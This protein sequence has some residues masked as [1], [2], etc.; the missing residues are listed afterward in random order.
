MP[1]RDIALHRQQNQLLANT[2]YDNPA[3]AVAWMGAIQAQEIENAK[4]TI[5]VRT[6][7]AGM[8]EIE[9]AIAAKSIVRTWPM[10]G[11]LHFVA[12]SD[13]HWMLSLLT[14]RIVANSARR[15]N[16]LELDE[17]VFSKSRKILIRS[18]KDG[19]ILTRKSLYTILESEKIPTGNQRGIHILQK[20]AMEGLICFGPY[21]EREPTFVLLDEWI[22]RTSVHGREEALGSLAIRYFASHGPAQLKDFIWWTGLTTA[23]AKEAIELAGTRLAR[24]SFKE[25]IYRYDTSVRYKPF[26]EKPAVLL[27]GFDEYILGYTD[28]SDVIS[29][30]HIGKLTP[31]GGMFNRTIVCDGRVIGIWKRNNKKG[32][33]QID[34]HPFSPLSNKQ[35]IAVE[36]AKKRYHDFY[37]AQAH[38]T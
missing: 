32:K 28:R 35:D 25:K 23:M 24:L 10:R 7:S 13:I 34:I 11:T 18:L 5:A 4:W 17:S 8:N 3:D 15:Y 1:D 29:E 38:Y 31:G 20:H 12:G 36:L 9:K 6:R 2:R 37:G 26:N 27:P 21:I 16:Q 33:F 30:Q 22:P 14:P 19:K